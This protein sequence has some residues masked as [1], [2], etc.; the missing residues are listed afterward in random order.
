[1]E[2]VVPRCRFV[3]ENQ[4][5]AQQRIVQFVGIA[6]EGPGVLA[7]LGDGFGVELCQVAEVLDAE[8]PPRAHRSCPPLFQ[9]GIVEKRVRI[10][11]EDLMRKRRRLA[12]VD[13]KKFHLT[14][15]HVLQHRQ[16][17]RQVHC[18]GQAVVHRLPHDGMIG[19]LDVAVMV[20]QAA[21]R[22]GKRLRQQILAAE[23]LQ[24]RRHL[25]PIL[26][27]QNGQRPRNVPPP[28]DAEHGNRQER[29]LQ[30]LL[31]VMRPNHRKQTLDG[32][33]VLRADGEQHPV[34]V[35]CRLQLKI[36]AAAEAF[37]QSESPGP[38]DP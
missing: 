37:A 1:M 38:V 12:G 31:T 25:F 11:V 28:A 36:K 29:L 32:E 4:N 27:P 34:F 9:R 13:R 5:E 35:R 24:E 3:G 18:L 33:A 8:R 23:F 20:L 6:D 16:P 7:D 10:G 15:L 17:S 26:H 21:D 22:F 14:V 2:R 30:Q 19:D